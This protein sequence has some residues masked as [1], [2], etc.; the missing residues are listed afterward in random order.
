MLTAGFVAGVPMT[1]A[2]D[3][4]PA[5]GAEQYG[6]PDAEAPTHEHDHSAHDFAELRRQGLAGIDPAAHS[7]HAVFRKPVRAA[8]QR[9]RWLSGASP[10]LCLLWLPS[11]PDWPFL[12]AGCCGVQ[13][14]NG[15][16]QT[17]EVMELD[18]ELSWAQL[19][20][21]VEQALQTPDQDC[22]GLLSRVR[23]RFERSEPEPGLST[24]HVWASHCHVVT[25]CQ[26]AWGGIGAKGL[27]SFVLCLAVQPAA[28]V[29]PV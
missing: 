18:G 3:E 25:C 4:I 12:S 19:D 1:F 17:A 22:E 8:Q 9:A 26:E 20:T 13:D 15:E 27:D 23:E 2:R 14:Q 21:L 11:T 29:R 10:V 28:C 6:T 7:R 16:G 5:A 24:L